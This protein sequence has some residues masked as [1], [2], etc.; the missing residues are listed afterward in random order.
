M[1]I[2]IFY[3]IRHLAIKTFISNIIVLLIVLFD[4]IVM[5]DE[6]SYFLD[7]QEG[8]Y[9]KID[10]KWAIVR[11]IDRL[12]NLCA[13]T[14]SE[15]QV[16]IGERERM[17]SFGVAMFERMVEHYIDV[18]YTNELKE[19]KEDPKTKS[20]GELA[21]ALN[22]Y[23]CLLKLLGRQGFLMRRIRKGSG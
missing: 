10:I 14:Q 12:N 15:K 1:N 20:A 7:E 3:Y 16:S 5:S 21:I 13:L 19:F 4:V 6:S 18:K 17:L 11:H 9:D 22:K 2:Y 23:G 8:S